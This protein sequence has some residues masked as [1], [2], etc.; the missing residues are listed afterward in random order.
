MIIN[1]IIVGIVS[2]MSNDYRGI[3]RFMSYKNIYIYI[4]HMIYIYAQRLGS[5]QA[6]QRIYLQFTNK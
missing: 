4:Y 3:G 6:L 2:D 5:A 1:G